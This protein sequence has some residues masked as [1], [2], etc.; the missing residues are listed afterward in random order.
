MDPSRKSHGIEFN[1]FS[2]AIHQMD[3]I[4]SARGC[5][6]QSF[7]PSHKSLSKLSSLD[8]AAWREPPE[9]SVGSWCWN[10]RVTRQTG[11]YYIIIQYD[12]IIYDIKI[13]HSLGLIICYLGQPCLIF[14]FETFNILLHSISAMGD[15]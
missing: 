9:A 15:S 8:G 3:D 4:E 10:L 11:I 14:Q 2:M 1:V 13:V 6:H 12:I 5:N 7:F